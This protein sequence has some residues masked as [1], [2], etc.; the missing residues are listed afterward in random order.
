MDILLSNVVAAVQFR[1]CFIDTV[2]SLFDVVEGA[3][4]KDVSFADQYDSACQGF[5][6]LHVMGG[7]D[8]SRTRGS[9]SALK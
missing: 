6:I 8:D 5:D 4:H 7:K 2:I 1:H 9:D 3:V